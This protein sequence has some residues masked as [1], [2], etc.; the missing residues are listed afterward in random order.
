MGLTGYYRKFIKGYAQIASPLTNQ[1]KKDCFTWDEAAT[2][3]FEELKQAMTAAPILAM[4]NFDI[5]FILETDASGV[6]SGAVLMQNNH[7]IAFF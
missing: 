5:P 4:P 2:T 3:A 7:P 1:L 6:G